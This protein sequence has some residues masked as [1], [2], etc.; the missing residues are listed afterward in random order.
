M[1]HDP[2]RED[3]LR[4][5]LRFALSLDAGSS[6][7]APRAFAD[8]GRRFAQQRD[9]LPQSDADRAF[10]LVVLATELID[11]RLPFVADDRQAEALERRAGALLD[12]ALSLDPACHDAARMR[13]F[14]GTDSPEERCRF[15]AEGEGEVRSACEAERDRAGETLDGERASLAAAIAML[16]YW[17]WLAARAEGALV[18][19]RN[20][21]AAEL[22]WRLLEADPRD[23]SDARFTLALALAKLED[24]PAL[25]RLLERCQKT[26]PMRPADDAWSLLAQVALAHRRFDLAAARRHL[27]RLLDAYPDGA[28]A[29]VRQL[30]VA[31]GT[32]ARVRVAPYSVDELVV[33]LSEGIV[34][35]QEGGLP[36]GI[37]ALGA[38]VER[39]VLEMVPAAGSGERAS[40]G[41]TGGA[42]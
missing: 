7:P 6:E 15:L 38:W 17:R 29:L 10:H 1:A 18:C 20:R 5:S 27:S 19:G 26:S 30:E 25:E 11:Y 22:A 32:F 9:T 31:S 16:P 39:T 40:A 2:Q 41:G 23:T 35:L 33:A 34:L 4:L 37:G 24:E 12:E 8:F 3:Y 36:G 14:L 21:E 28:P 42:S 13:F